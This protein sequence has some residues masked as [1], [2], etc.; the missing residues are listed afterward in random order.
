MKVGILTRE[1]HDLWARKFDL[2][3]ELMGFNV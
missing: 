1:T 3:L 2:G